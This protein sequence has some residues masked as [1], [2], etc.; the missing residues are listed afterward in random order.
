MVDPKRP[1]VAGAAVLVPN[2]LGAA[3]FDCCG[4]CSEPPKSP[5]AGAVVLPN[6]VPVFFSPPVFPKLKDMFASGSKSAQLDGVYVCTRCKYARSRNRTGNVLSMDGE[7]QSACI[8]V[9]KAASGHAHG[10][11]VMRDRNECCVL[12]SD[13][14]DCRK[15]QVAVQ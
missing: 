8:S 6:S 1:P 13:Y 10:V 9:V 7:A 14:F 15:L 5:P 12:G 2:K 3:A 4:C 11:A